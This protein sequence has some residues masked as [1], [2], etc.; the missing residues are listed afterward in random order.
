M[1]EHP[2]S[3]TETSNGRPSRWLALTGLSLW[4]ALCSLS[5]HPL[6]W[7]VEQFFLIA[8][9]PWPPLAWPVA[10]VIHSVLLLLPAL[11]L[12]RLW[13]IRADQ[14]FFIAFALT[15]LFI[16]ALA[17]MRLAGY[18]A[19]LPA[20]TMQFICTL[21]FIAILW[22]LFRLTTHN[23]SFNWRGGQVWFAFLLSPFLVL[24][25]LAWGAPGSWLDTLLNL[26][27]ALLLGVVASIILGHYLL[28]PLYQ[29]AQERPSTWFK[30]GFVAGSLLLTLGAGMGTNGQ[31]L[32]LMPVLG[33]LGWLVVGLANWETG[34][35]EIGEQRSRGAEEITIRNPQTPISLVVGLATAAPLILVDPDELM[36]TLNLGTRD[37]GTWAVYATVVS[38]VAALCIGVLVIVLRQPL[39]R[40][41]GGVVAQG[42][43]VVLWLSAA[44]LFLAVGQPGFYG[45]RLFVI[46]REQADV[47]AA[48]TITDDTAR[49]QWVYDTLTTHADR[50]QA[51]L[52]QTLDRFYVGYTA[53]YL[54]NALEVRGGPLLRWWLARRPEV[55]RVLD[56]P[57]MRPLPLLPAPDSGDQPAPASPLWNLTTIGAPQVWE[58]VGHTGEGIIIGHSD[59][60]VDGNHPEVSDNYRG[61]QTGSND[62]NWFD[63]WYGSAAPR[64]ISGHGT[65][66]LGI[67]LGRSVGVA[68]GAS[69]IGC[70]NLARNLGNPALYLDC[71]QFM[72]APFPHGGDPLHDGRP[73]LGATSSTTHGAARRLKA[74]MPT[75][76]FTQSTLYAPPVSLSLPPPETRVRTVPAFP[77]RLPSTTLHFQ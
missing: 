35:F 6:L 67:A 76:C 65:H 18:T 27:A 8:E 68:P 25:W 22:G 36:L 53:Y 63:P 14:P 64:D 1:A 61:R 21:V 3:A 10:A 31:Q 55:E 16:L 7:L 4:F 2:S 43:I 23:G 45:E 39:S 29:E 72:L 24:G 50:T 49:R 77:I 33:A 51:G 30:A 13:P 26:L 54:V 75:L 57:V 38:V 37:V 60:G 73:D 56:S 42:L 58:T 17:P 11:L 20:A 19:A 40:W 46:L 69:W 66:T 5:I 47:S 62:Y 44:A 59:S 71:M 9:E 28:P 15:A 12:L 52:R 74:A 70:V 34:R 32:I 41:Q 48:P